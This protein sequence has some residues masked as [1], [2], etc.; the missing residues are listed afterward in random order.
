[1]PGHAG[2]RSTENRRVS[3]LPAVALAPAPRALQR[4]FERAA[5]CGLCSRACHVP[6]VRL[7]RHQCK[8]PQ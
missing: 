8:A 7:W 6:A 1:V 2:R 5:A 3:R 4:R